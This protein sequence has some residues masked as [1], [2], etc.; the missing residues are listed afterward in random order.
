[1]K[2]V[3]SI[4]IALAMS[5]LLAAC[6][7]QLASAPH[8]RS[9]SVVNVD[10]GGRAIGTRTDGAYGSTDLVLGLP[11]HGTYSLRHALV[12]GGYRFLWHKYS[13]ELG[14]DLGVGHPVHEKWP[15]TG[16]YVGASSSLL[17]RIHGTQDSE[18]GYSPIGVL[19]DVVLS[20]RGGVW[21]PP[22]G[23][24]G[25]PVGDASM[26]IG[27][28]VSFISDLAVATNRNWER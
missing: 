24:T 5:S 14:A 25:A 17:R 20:V 1:M 18:V 6:A 12:G 26:L 19:L 11:E 2:R 13:F 3:S 9:A 7:V 4:L 28:R 21:N 10:L 23:E 16:L 15:G 27:L 22:A 8:V